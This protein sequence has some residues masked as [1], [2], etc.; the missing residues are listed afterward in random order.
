MAKR[1][2]WAG[3]VVI[4]LAAR[5][6]HLHVLWVE[7]AYPTAA[8]LELLR[9]KALYR[10]IWFD[11]PPLFAYIYTLWGAQTGILLRLAGAAFCILASWAAA[12]AARVFWG[13][14]E[15]LWAAALTAF[16]LTFDTP[17]AVLALTPDLLT[18]PL[19][20]AAVALAA[21]GFPLYA[22]LCAGVS[23]LF[24]AKGLLIL[25][26][27]C[28]WQW[29]NLPKLAA[30]FAAPVL[31]GALALAFQGS[32]TAFWQQVWVWGAAYSRD[33]PFVHPWVE[34]ARRTLNWSG[35]HVAVIA[36]VFVAAWKQ[37]DW[38]WAAWMLL[39]LAGVF[40][41]F[42]FF[43]R[44]YFHLLPVLV[45]LAAQGL[46]MLP[47]R[48][49]A[50]L[51]LLLIIPAVRFGP[52][53]LAVA[54]NKPWPDLGLYESSVHAADFLKKQ[55]KPGDTLLVYGYR[56]DLYPL[57]GL[58]AGTRFL[59]SQPLTGV[60]AD[61]HLLSAKVT[62]PEVAAANRQA[63]QSAPRPQWIADGLGPYNPKLDVR[64]ILP[65][66]LRDYELA[67]QIPGYRLFRLK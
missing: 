37:E 66:L 23:L 7:E 52:R 43:P 39:S 54:Q 56:P 5:L 36:G 55:A 35:F 65:D 17:S 2:L 38:R 24:N 15:S 45:L 4:L 49:A 51:A 3:I 11:K 33:T 34:G 10:D 59:D 8:A 42:R 13:E 44:Y 67:A 47:R 64:D 27:C 57:S 26:A 18:L 41:G 9:G 21:A 50:I 31:L 22:G 12:R 32:L 14:R 60:I 28:L 40:L 61:R 1:A 48:W 6:C 63:L 19:H 25:A 16:F 53:Y 30:G 20:F 58:P 46:A 62:F 29:R